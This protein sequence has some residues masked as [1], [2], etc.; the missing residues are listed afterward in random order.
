MHLN[1]IMQKV[2]NLAVEAGWWTDYE[3]DRELPPEVRLSKHMLMV[4]ELAEASE[5]VRNKAPAYY[6]NS[7]HGRVV[8]QDVGGSHNLSAGENLLKP[9]GELSELADVVI[10]VMDYCGFHGW[11]LEAAIM[12]KHEYNKTRAFR[13]GGKAL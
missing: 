8:H 5:E 4:T 1:E 2:H 9:E 13:H 7:S 12:A 3:I 11:D 10:R 6:W